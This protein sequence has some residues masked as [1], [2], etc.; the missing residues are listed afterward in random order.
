MSPT[1]PRTIRARL[2]TTL[3]VLASLIVGT[4]LGSPARAQE[5]PVIP[6]TNKW[7]LTP[8]GDNPAEPSTKANLSYELAPGGVTT[9][10]VTVWNYSDHPLTFRVYAT[11]A[12]TTPT[13][14]YDLLP[15]TQPPVD[16]GSW[17]QLDQGSVTVPANS[18]RGIN[19]T[20]RVPADAFPGDH[21]GGVVASLTTPTTGADGK[22]VDVENRTG[23]RLYT[24]VAG[25]LDPSLVVEHLSST[26]HRGFFAFGG[27]DLD[28][29]YTVRNVG[30][31][32]LAAHRTITVEG[33]FGWTLLTQHPE[34]VPELL[35]GTAF[36][37]TAHLT[38]VLPAFY[39]TTAV[40]LDPFSP[41]GALAGDPPR[42]TGSTGTRA[43]PWLLVILVVVV[44]GSLVWRGRERRR[45]R[46]ALGRVVT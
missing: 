8:T 36:T 33:P 28:V 35:P 44:I 13:G 17:V 29:T 6:P 12:F 30:N 34:D 38:G 39:V 40:S 22:E 42:A 14:A 18:G 23:T 15:R 1:A 21:S 27:G 37:V 5:G 31:I 32:R 24:R 43:V 46:T 7:A 45:R 9:D 11:D 20:L 19:L 41:S 16:V 3:V 10:S 4:G 2:A 25:E 26:Y